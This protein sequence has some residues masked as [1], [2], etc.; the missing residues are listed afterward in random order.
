MGKSAARVLL[1]VVQKQILRGSIWPARL[2]T[3]VTNI[4]YNLIIIIEG[5]AVILSDANWNF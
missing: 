3:R 2:Q 5:L 4:F 1:H